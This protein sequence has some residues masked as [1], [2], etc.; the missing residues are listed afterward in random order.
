M[1]LALVV[2][3]CLKQCRSEGF[4][5][6]LVLRPDGS[7]V[8]QRGRSTSVEGL[9]MWDYERRLSNSSHLLS[10]LVFEA[11]LRQIRKPQSHSH[12]HRKPTGC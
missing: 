3:P 10:Q 9:S 4:L 7:I 1:G 6:S 12:R 11:W 2:R 5:S 8:P